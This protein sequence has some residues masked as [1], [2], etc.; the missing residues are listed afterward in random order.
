MKRFGRRC[1]ASL[2]DPMPL[3]WSELGNVSLHVIE[4]AEQRQ[5]LASDLAA[6]VGPEVMELAP[7]VRHAAGFD[8]SVLEQGLV[9]GIVVADQLALPVADELSR[10]ASTA[11]LGEVVDDTLD[12]VILR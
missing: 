7:G 8:D 3:A 10:V 11:G 1:G 5:R 12:V 9:S 4:R 2:P 6:V